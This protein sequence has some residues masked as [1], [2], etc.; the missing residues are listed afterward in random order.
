MH[1]VDVCIICFLDPFFCGLMDV[2]LDVPLCGLC[3]DPSCD[4]LNLG[5]NDI[6][7]KSFVAIIGQTMGGIMPLTV[8]ERNLNQVP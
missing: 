8:K 1:T 3:L 7:C 4:L 2:I 6:D 5:H